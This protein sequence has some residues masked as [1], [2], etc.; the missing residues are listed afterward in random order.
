MEHVKQ[1]FHLKFRS[2]ST[3]LSPIGNCIIHTI[4]RV[5]NNKTTLQMQ[6]C[7][8]HCAQNKGYLSFFP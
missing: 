1:R 6:K 4:G 7:N 3:T 2:Y 8:F 5:A